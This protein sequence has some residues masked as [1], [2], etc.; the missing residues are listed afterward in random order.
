MAKKIKIS[1]NEKETKNTKVER[2]PKA[3]LN[4]LFITLKIIFAV[5]LVGSIIYYNSELASLKKENKSLVKKNNSLESENEEIHSN[6]FSVIGTDSVFYV[7]NKLDFFDDNIAFQIE[8]FGNYYYS[9]DC[10]MQKVNGYYSYWAYNK[11]AA[12][13]KGL[14][15]G[16]C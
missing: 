1:A 4:I 7:S 14:R 12:I 5:S 6:L 3:K 16:G 9:Y 2:K 10:M 11:E 13:S 15:A 8:G